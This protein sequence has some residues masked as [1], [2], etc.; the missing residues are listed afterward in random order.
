MGKILKSDTTVAKNYLDEKHIKE[1]EQ[2]VSAYLDLAE[3]RAGR[4]IIMNMSDW[5]VFL[6]KFI[7]LS[8]YPILKDAGKISKLKAEIKAGREYS[9]FRVVQDKNFESDFDLEIKKYLKPGS[10]KKKGKK[11]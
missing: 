6:N 4:Q 5:V 3:N 8:D 9:K 7:E 11:K 2:V 1:L 10:K